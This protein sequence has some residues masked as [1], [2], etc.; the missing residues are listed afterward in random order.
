M[1]KITKLFSV[2]AVIAALFTLNSCEGLLPGIAPENNG[3]GGNGKQIQYDFKHTN[4]YAPWTEVYTSIQKFEYTKDGVLNTPC[5]YQIVFT[6]KDTAKTYGTWFFYTRRCDS[7]TNLETVAQGTYTGDAS[8]TGTIY[9]KDSNGKDY[10]TIQIAE[11]EVLC[12]TTDVSYVHSS[13]GAK[14]AK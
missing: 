11:Q 1:K 14:D 3:N 13:I 4:T 6:A 8:K 9:L 7:T 10:A 12:F 5:Q 2:L